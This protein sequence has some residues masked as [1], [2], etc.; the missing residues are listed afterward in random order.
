MKVLK[1]SQVPFLSCCRQLWRFL[2]IFFKNSFFLLAIF[3][4]SS[5]EKG[6]FDGIFL[7]GNVFR[8]MAKI[9]HHKN[10]WPEEGGLFKKKG[11]KKTLGKY[12]CVC[13][14]CVKRGVFAKDLW[15][16][17]CCKSCQASLLWRLEDFCCCCLFAKL[18]RERKLNTSFS[19]R[20]REPESTF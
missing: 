1:K 10:H 9:R 13:V 8:R 2:S 3:V 19:L 6:N 15:R 14:S 16:E 12:V 11:F 20:S 17:T 5:F 4:F 7:F 18:L